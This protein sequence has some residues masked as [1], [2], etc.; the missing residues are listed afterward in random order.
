MTK[1]KHKR[2]QFTS[3]F[4]V[5][6]AATGSAVGLG[7]IW[8]FPYI[9][10]QHGG[11]A[12]L[13]VYLCFIVTIGSSVMLAEFFI[14]RKSR[15]NAFGAFK[16]L[17]PKSAWKYS[18]ILG[19]IAS[20]L[21]ISFYTV[22]S[23]WAIEYTFLALKNSFVDQNTEQLASLFT[24]FTQSPF[25]PL[26][27]QFIFL[28]ATAGILF[29][30]VKNGIEKG[31]KFMM[32]LLV[33]III[34]LDI[35]S[36]SL[37]GASRGLEFLF[38]PDF[39]KLTSE[40]ILAA[41]GHAFFS[42]SLGAGSLI[43]YGSYINNENNL[44]RTTCQITLADTLIAILAGVA[45]LPAVFAFG[46]NPCEGPGLVF[47]TLPNIFT[48][49]SGGY[50][51]A[52]LFFLLLTLAALTSSISILEVIV[53]YFSEELKMKRRAAIIVA[54]CMIMLAGTICSLSLGAYHELNIGGMN[55][56]DGADWLASNIL[57]PLS[58]LLISLFIGWKLPKQSIYDELRKGS[59][60]T[61]NFVNVFV[62]I[63]R[64][65]APIGIILVFLNGLGIFS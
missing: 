38:K 22:V 53:V 23:G 20:M 16:K 52:I 44:V 8:K 45:I 27:Y 11:A 6:A 15:K 62:F 36:L 1:K 64:Y 30:G 19:I 61:M 18:G 7:N 63:V 65:I 31:S 47:I 2:V 46:I 33:L 13:V 57:L 32:P 25:T 43:T 4:G 42:L 54:T 29:A 12:F 28:C 51:F 21:I 34:I 40:A 39:S 24:N 26:L 9:T 48:Q 14:G 41:L 37:P 10:G 49:M 58:G 60:V 56:F 50:F 17:A 3:K 59:R 5:I 35:K 55:I